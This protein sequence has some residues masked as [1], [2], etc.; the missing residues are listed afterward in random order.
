MP[1]GACVIRYDGQRGVVWRIKFTDAKGRQVKETLGRAVDGWNETKAQRALG[2]RL[3]DVERERWSKPTRETFAEFVAE[4]RTVWIPARKLKGA[5]IADYSNTLDRHALPVLGELLL[6]GIGPAQIERYV[7]A[8]L[9]EGL[10]SKTVRNHLALLNVVFKTAKRWKRIRENPLDDVDGPTLDEPETTILTDEEIAALLAALRRL[11]FDA[12]PAEGVR[13]DVVRR[14]VVVAIGTAL[15][16]GELLA[17]KWDD[18]NLLE[19]RLQVRRSMWRGVET[20]PKSR[21]GRRT[22]DFGLKTAAAFEEQWRATRYS[23]GTEVVF[24]HPELGTPLDPG[25]IHR[26][27][28]KPAMAKAGITKPGAWHVLRHTS[29]TADAACGNPGPYV[30]AKAGHSSYAITERYIHAAQTAFPGAV[31]RAE[32]RLFGAAT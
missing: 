28:L 1:S 14:M 15:R 26:C 9:S 12:E 17:L 13:F 22:I 11:A 19:R 31:E 5:T 27:Y 6:E 16:R 10:A 18:V 25:K 24:G 21:A 29:L 2:K 4:W 7:A 30:Q 8:K 20:T 23:R 32:E 3:A